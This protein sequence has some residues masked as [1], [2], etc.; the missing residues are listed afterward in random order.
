MRRQ[1]RIL[2]G[3]VAALLLVEAAFIGYTINTPK[4]YQKLEAELQ[5]TKIQVE[6]TYHNLKDKWLMNTG[7]I[8]DAIYQTEE[9]VIKTMY[10][11][12][13]NL[14]EYNGWY[15]PFERLKLSRSGIPTKFA[16][17]ALFNRGNKNCKRRN[18]AKQVICNYLEK[19]RKK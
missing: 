13:E 14:D 10:P 6:D 1:N 4:G 7:G 18:P 17:D 15:R 12:V 19:Q 11:N 9:D 3:L 2:S 5:I 8:A 16:E